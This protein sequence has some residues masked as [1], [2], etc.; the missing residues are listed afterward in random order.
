MLRHLYNRDECV[1]SYS[2]VMVCCLC[3]TRLCVCVCVLSC[4]KRKEEVEVE[5]EV[6]VEEE[7]KEEDEKEN[8][9]KETSKRHLSLQRRQGGLCKVS[10]ITSLS[11][12]MFT[13]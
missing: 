3:V 6:E 10:I 5:V 2:Q 11:K 4:C 7:E 1:S 12:N 8:K 13:D 9:F